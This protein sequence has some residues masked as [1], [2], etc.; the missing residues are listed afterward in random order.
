M[1]D[2]DFYLRLFELLDYRCFV[3]CETLDGDLL[4]EH[5]VEDLREY[6][7][8]EPQ[9]SELL[10]MLLEETEKYYL[11]TIQVDGNVLVILV[12]EDNETVVFNGEA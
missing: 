12:Q 1:K 3:R 6:V 7:N 2:Y 11:E 10:D 8:D 5:F 9:T 4:W